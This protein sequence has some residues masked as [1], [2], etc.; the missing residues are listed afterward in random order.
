MRP[1]PVQLVEQAP[2]SRIQVIAVAM[3][4][5][6]NA[7]DGFD[8]LSVSFAAPGI[9]QEFGVSHSMLGTV[10]AAEL[11]GMGFGSIL[12]GN[13]ADKRGR[14]FTILLC[15]AIT[16]CGMLATA[17]VSNIYSLLALRV[18]TGF[19]IGGTLAA[20]TAAAAE[21]SNERNRGL[22]VAFSAVG[23]PVG[24][25]VGGIVA[26]WLLTRYSWHSVFL[27]GSVATFICLIATLFAMPETVPQLCNRPRRSSLVKLNKLLKRMGHEE[28]AALPSTDGP[29]PAIPLAQL[30]SPRWIKRTLLVSAATA[31]H[32]GTF[33]FLIK[34]LPTIAVGQGF[35]ASAAGGVMVWSNIGGALGGIAAG[36]IC[37]YVSVYT[38]AIGVMLLSFIMLSLFGFVPSSLILLAVA[39]AITSFFTN[40]GIATVYSVITDVFSTQVRAA[41][42]GFAIG[43]GRAGAAASPILAG[44]LFDSGLSLTSVAMTMGCGAL[45]GSFCLMLIDKTSP[46]ES[47]APA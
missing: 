31:L 3:T 24:G 6:L 13:L 29:A 10:L 11:V 5:L 38:T 23:Y 44:F 14:R 2:M 45:A 47:T 21:H 17:L 8:V 9:S 15:L 39:A 19:G 4:I 43:V 32:M 22:C 34:W 46:A 1:T 26:S 30:F 37:R 16:G 42:T 27:F 18:I 33:Y 25:I 40:G 35:S 28:V 20:I 36:F 41:G 12:L 7:L